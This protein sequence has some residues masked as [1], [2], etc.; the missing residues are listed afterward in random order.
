MKT[1]KK[2]ERYM[3]VPLYKQKLK[4]RKQPKQYTKPY[5]CKT[6]AMWN[7]TLLHQ[8]LPKLVQSTQPV[9]NRLAIHNSSSPFYNY[10]G[11][12]IKLWKKPGAT[13]LRLFG[14]SR[15][16]TLTL[17]APKNGIFNGYLY[18]GTWKHCKLSNK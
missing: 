15:I 1:H 11:R 10:A 12:L 18:F 3:S 2:Y 13:S 16:G 4:Y 7:C 17:S 6:P 8:A 14:N 5:I 9:I